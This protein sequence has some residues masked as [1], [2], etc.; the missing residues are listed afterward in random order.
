MG[1]KIFPND[2]TLMDN[3]AD[4]DIHVII[5]SPAKMEELKKSDMIDRLLESN[6]TIAHLSTF[7]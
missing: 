1:V 3:L 5:V 6:I 7:K 4:K 2:D